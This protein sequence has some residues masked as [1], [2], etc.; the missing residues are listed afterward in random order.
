MRVTGASLRGLARVRDPHPRGTS[1]RPP[2]P[3]HR[4]AQPS[5]LSPHPQTTTRTPP[6]GGAAQATMQVTK[7]TQWP[8]PLSLK[9]TPLTL[10]QKLTIR[11]PHQHHLTSTGTLTFNAHKFWR[12]HI[13]KTL[14]V[15]KAH[16]K[17]LMFWQ[18]QGKKAVVKRNLTNSNQRRFGTCWKKLEQDLENS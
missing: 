10:L 15:S 14:S 17:I 2:P 6:K 13:F 9:S 16:F 12:D 7:K 8:L 4:Q 3:C 1:P 18:A 11:R 5:S